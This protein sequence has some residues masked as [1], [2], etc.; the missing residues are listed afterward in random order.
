[1][2]DLE[3]LDR[4]RAGERSAGDALIRRHFDPICRFFRSKLSEDVEDLVQRTFLDCI[5]SHAEIQPGGF[6]AYLFAVARHRLYDHLRVA[7]RRGE[8]IDADEITLFDLG[9]S[10]SQRVARNQ[11]EQLLAE[12]LRRIPLDH[13]IALELAYWEDLSGDEIAQVLGIATNTARSRL[14]RAR[15]AVR[16]RL[17]ELAAPLAAEALAALDTAPALR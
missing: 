3:L 8:P 10:P 4:W 14:A 15:A 6:R 7:H 13:Q 1:V 16:E 5:E 17:G 2:D 11:Q 12:A 9:T